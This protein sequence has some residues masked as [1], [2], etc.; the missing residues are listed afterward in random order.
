MAGGH[1]AACANLRDNFT[2]GHWL[3]AAPESVRSPVDRHH[4]LLRCGR[5]PTW[6]G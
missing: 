3:F 6:S 4:L 1:P 2:I 5:L